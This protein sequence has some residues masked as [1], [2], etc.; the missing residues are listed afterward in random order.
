MYLVCLGFIYKEM[1]P[2]TLK[3]G[4]QPT[5]AIPLHVADLV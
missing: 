2:E 1:P 5:P 4:L 3:N